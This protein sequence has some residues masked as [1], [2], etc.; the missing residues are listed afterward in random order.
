LLNAVSQLRDLHP[1]P[2]RRSSDLY[3]VAPKT[4]AR[5]GYGISYVHNNRVGSAD[6]LGINGPQVVI[7]TVDQTPLLANGQ[8]NPDFRTT[9]QRSEE[10][11][12][13]LQS[14]FELVCRLLLE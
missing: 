11:T 10:H 14:R 6:L 13:E 12:S 7:A 3:T 9:Q 8:V 4:V 2:T 1:F 5:G